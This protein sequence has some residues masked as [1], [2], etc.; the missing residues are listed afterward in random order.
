MTNEI[1]RA[2]DSLAAQKHIRL[3]AAGS[4]TVRAN[5]QEIWELIYNLIDNAIRYGR[6][7]GSVCVRIDGAGFTVVD[8]GI[9]IPKDQIARIFERFYRVDKSHNR[10]TGGTG[11][12]FRSSGTS[13]RNMAA[14][15]PSKA[16][17][18]RAARSSCG[19]QAPKNKEQ[20]KGLHTNGIMGRIRHR[21]RPDRRDHAARGP[22]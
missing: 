18:A 13:R 19:C 21:P 12:A 5:A 3:E 2:L 4:G 10:Q 15:S 7:G 20:N 9:G 17:K 22:F 6:D 14:A 16:R 1:L 8:D 11:L